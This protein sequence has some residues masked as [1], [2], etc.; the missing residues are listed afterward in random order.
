MVRTF[1]QRIELRNGEA[2]I[3]F[4]VSNPTRCSD[5]ARI[6]EWSKLNPNTSNIIYTTES[7][8]VYLMFPY[9]IVQLKIE[10]KGNR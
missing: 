9:I 3:F 7:S 1:I 2:L 10:K 4:N 6:L 8:S 5:T